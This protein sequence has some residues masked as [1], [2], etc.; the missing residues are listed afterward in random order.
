M[1]KSLKGKDLG[2]GIDQLNDGRY[3]A[4]YLNEY[5][6][7]VAIY[8]KNLAKLKRELKNKQKKILVVKEINNEDSRILIDNDITLNQLYERWRDVEL[9]PSERKQNTKK[10]YI[11]IYNHNIK[12]Y[13]GNLKINSLNYD[14]CLETFNIVKQE[15][16]SAT[17]NT[18]LIVLRLIMNYG[19]KNRYLKNNPCNDV[20][21]NRSNIYKVVYLTEKEQDIFLKYSMS[22]NEYYT[23]IFIIALNTGMR[24]GEILGLTKDEIDFD[25][26]IINIKHQLQYIS[27]KNTQYIPSE[28]IILE[29]KYSIAYLTE[30]KSKKS[31]RIIPINN[32]TKEA[33][34]WLINNYNYINRH[35]IN[36]VKKEDIKV[37]NKN[38]FK[39]LLI[40]YNNRN[41]SIQ[42]LDSHIHYTI[43][44]ILKDYPNY[45]IKELTMHG[46]RHTFATRCLDKN[47]STRVIQELLGHEHDRI[48]EKYA[49]VTEYKIFDEF[50]NL[51]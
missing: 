14:N 47:I 41:V 48:T 40:V 5:G 10:L 1:G 18:V 2:K 9:L 49:H 15:K 46:L 22:R 24:A 21:S 11:T 25:N 13:L 12:K 42:T 19:V 27:K 23:R 50:K 20:R 39:N 17:A 33:L 31:K 36:K 38:I 28:S 7:R 8:D 43:Q 26:N 29:N 4:R 45:R 37:H 6:K 32:N 30:P 3:R 35:T 16:S 51:F 34:L 44:A